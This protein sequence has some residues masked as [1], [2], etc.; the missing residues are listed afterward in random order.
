MRTSTRTAGRSGI[1]GALVGAVLALATLLAAIGMSAPASAHSG[2][3]AV[4]LVRSFTLVP[5]GDA[6][7]ANLTLADLDSGTAIPAAD[8]KVTAGSLPP[9]ALAHSDTIEGTYSAKIDKLAPGTMDIRLVVRTAP[10]GLPVALFDT[11]YPGI[12]VAAGQ[13]TV[14][15]SAAAG[16]GGGGSN[17]GMIIGVAGAVLL[18]AL[19]YGLFTV[20]RRGAVPARVK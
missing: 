2:G 4:V 17:T 20:R 8:A 13:E 15:T 3:K 9:V 1:R 11:T 6:W 7:Q 18:V 10:G 5:V 19:L 16:G 14:I 12:T